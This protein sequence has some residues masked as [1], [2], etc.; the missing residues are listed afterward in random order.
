MREIFELARAHLGG[1]EFLEQ[2][3]RA[4]QRRVPFDCS[5]G[6]LVD[7]ATAIA[8]IVVVAPGAPPELLP[9]L[10]RDARL[11][12]WAGMLN[13][14]QPARRL[15]DC[16][17]GALERIPRYREILAPLGLG[18]ELRANLGVGGRIWGRLLLAR[19]VSDPL[20]EDAEVALLAQASAPLAEGI[21]RSFLNGSPQESA[22]LD[23]LA[24]IVLD[25]DDR[26]VSC[27]D[28]ARMLLTPCRDGSRG[29]EELPT[30][31]WGVAMRARLENG[32]RAW[33]RIRCRGGR[34]ITV[35]G[36]ILDGGERVAITMDPSRPSE[37]AA[38][39]LDAYG[40]TARESQLVQYVL[41]AF[42][43]DDVAEALGI[44]PYT[45][46]DHLK[47]IFDKMGLSSRRELAARLF[48]VHDAT[49]ADDGARRPNRCAS[50]WSR[51]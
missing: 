24:V 30:A 34:W 31:L 47:S 13:L 8:T 25:E 48:L 16:A 28:A 49:R 33:A 2:A 29:S 19:R 44:S 36:A 46:Q 21:R 43:T 11:R 6:A 9:Q 5:I 41:R 20:F 50:L 26:V 37:V 17:G 7:P 3:L 4:I 18:D 22:P 45:V 39:M 38:L 10:R 35:R 40:L 51:T 1:I 12:G 23:A 14:R 32:N 42:S 15:S 27:T